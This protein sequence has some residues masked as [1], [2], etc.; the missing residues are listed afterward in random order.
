[1]NWRKETPLNEENAAL[2]GIMQVLRRGTA[3]IYNK[4][5]DGIFLRDTQSGA[6]ML[7][8]EDIEKGKFCL[9][10]LF[11]MAIEH[12]SLALFHV[13]NRSWIVHVGACIHLSKE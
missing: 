9:I 10:S 8:T 5:E 4:E 6:Y 2:A 11:H 7:C 13:F 12:F 1:M 3:Q